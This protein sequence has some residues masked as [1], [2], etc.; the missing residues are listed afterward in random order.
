MRILSFYQAASAGNQAPR[1]GSLLT[2]PCAWQLLTVRG[3]LGDEQGHARSE[4]GVV[5]DVLVLEEKGGAR[6]D[7]KTAWD[8]ALHLQTIA[9]NPASRARELPSLARLV[10][11]RVHEDALEVLERM[12]RG[13]EE[14]LQALEA[15]RAQLALLR[16][17]FRDAE[18]LNGKEKDQLEVRT[19]ALLQEQAEAALQA[20]KSLAQLHIAERAAAQATADAERYKTMLQDAEG[21]L[22]QSREVL[23]RLEADWQARENDNARLHACNAQQTAEILD[24]KQRVASSAHT[25]HH[26][27]PRTGAPAIQGSPDPF[28]QFVLDLVCIKS[29]RNDEGRLASLGRAAAAPSPSADCFSDNEEVS[30]TCSP[31]R[32]LGCGAIATSG[33]TGLMTDLTRPAAH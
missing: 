14:A 15:E 11:V 20:N 9:D 4:R 3:D 21:A 19:Q 29:L 8:H 13:S 6:H 17:N 31:T 27:S 32:E 12:G 1:G 30:F 16:L 28:K 23:A 24:L 7:L 33:C 5:V 10:E 18:E 25:N 2:D 26:L 22:A